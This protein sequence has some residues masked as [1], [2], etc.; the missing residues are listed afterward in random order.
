MQNDVLFWVWLSERLGAGSRDFRWLIMH[1]ET[2]YELFHM[3]QDELDRIE[4]ITD[5]TKEKLADKNLSR[6]SVIIRTCVEKGIEILP[7]GSPGYPILLR[8][9]ES[10]P[11]VL[12]CKGTLPEFRDRLSIAMVGTRKMSEYGMKTAYRFGFE[13][14]RANVTVVSGMAAGIDGVSAAAAMQAGGKTV[15]VLG[16]GV[17]VIYPKHHARLYERIQQNGAVISE[18]APGTRPNQYH[19]PARN[20][21]I[22]GLCQGTL[23]VEAG[24]KSGTLITA[25]KAVMQG[26]HLFS[27]PANVGDERWLG[28]NALLRDGAIPVLET[29][30]ILRVY[31]VSYGNVIDKNALIQ[32]HAES[33]CDLRLLAQL[34]VIETVRREAPV[35]ELPRET[36]EIPRPQRRVVPKPPAEKP[37]AKA[38]E[39]AYEEPEQLSLPEELPMQQPRQ[40]RASM[41]KEVIG[42]ILSAFPPIQ[43]DILKAIPYD[44]PIS[45]DELARLDYPFGDILAALTM[46]ELRGY[47]RKLPGAL[48]TKV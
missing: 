45:T 43:V 2:A 34:G 19:F 18:Y 10:P 25:R 46:L 30:D 5:R 20:R 37:M 32:A 22:S 9:L 24:L 26:R 11:I 21:I 33:V 35:T 40:D 3:D 14:A 23:V 44:R 39:Q 28:T 36:V 13:L 41:R 47:V 17:D 38:T 27:V 1:Y 8:D 29:E 48:Y 4:D 15:A 31:E 42:N 16:S 12:Y 7:F 6:A